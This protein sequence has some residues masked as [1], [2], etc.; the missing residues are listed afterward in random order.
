MSG[1]QEQG[2][3]KNS[4]ALLWWV[5]MFFLAGIGIWY[6]FGY[7][8]GMAFIQW[9]LWEA[10][11]ISMLGGDLRY[12]IP[13]LERLRPDDL[14]LDVINYIS[15]EIGFYLLWPYLALVALMGL[16]LTKGHVVLQFTKAYTMK[17]LAKQEQVNWPA[18]A[19]VVELNLIDQDPLKGPWSMALSPMQFC[20][21][22]KL[23]KIERLPD[24]RAAWRDEGVWKMTL[25]KQRA[26][27]VFV[28]QLGSLWEGV[29]ALPP[30][31]KGL[32]A[33][34]AARI[35]H[36]TEPAR[37]LLN[38]MSSS[39]A[40]GQINY[41]GAS[42]LLKKHFKHKAIQRILRHH[43]YVNTV[44]ASMLLLARTDGVQASSDFL[45][46]KVVDRPLWY[47]LN[48]VG[49]QTPY[50]EVAGIWAHWLFERELTRSICVPQVTNAVAGLETILAKVMYSPTEEDEELPFSNP[51]D[52]ASE[53]EIT[54]N[55][56]IIA[57]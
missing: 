22:Y 31:T 7:H 11:F 19:P 9:R 32:F 49:R 13:V 50:V 27:I 57:E 42:A 51:N 54:D 43:A 48:C 6:F 46:L 37:A 14:N 55:E 38:Q 2:G 24:P 56:D 15:S 33:V 20:K 28:R 17:S 4:M 3:D 52:P 34:F 8:L 16:L 30:H 53:E 18:I 23:L 25:L 26:H 1:G 40:A 21:K 5:V 39:Y 41:A 47:I 10:Q 35:A 36:N 29:N 45:W 44:M 12:L